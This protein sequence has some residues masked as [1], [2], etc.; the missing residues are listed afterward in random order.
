M[1]GSVGDHQ[2]K[3]SSGMKKI[4]A[5]RGYWQSVVGDWTVEFSRPQLS[6]LGFA[7]KVVKLSNYEDKR[8][9]S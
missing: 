7:P 1:S 4:S 5:T 8:I 3:E 9:S 6:V 2:G